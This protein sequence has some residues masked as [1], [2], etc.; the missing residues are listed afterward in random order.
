MSLYSSMVL[1]PSSLVIVL[2][3]AALLVLTT[4]TPCWYVMVT[5]LE[6][7]VILNSETVLS[8]FQ[9]E[10][11]HSATL[12]HPINSSSTKVA[13]FLSSTLKAANISFSD[14]VTKVAPLLFQAF[15]TVPHLAQISY[16]GMEG[17]FFSYYTDNDKVLAMYS[18]S[19][20]PSTSPW[21][22][23]KAKVY[24]IQPVNRDTG[25]LYGEA[26]VSEPSINSSLFAQVVINSSNGHASLGTKWNHAHDLLFISSAR[27]TG[28][29]GVSLGFPATTIANFLSH[30]GYQGASL[31]L[32][33]KDGKVLVEGIQ[34]TSMVIYNDTVSFQSVN[35]NGDHT[36][37]YDGTVSCKGG[38]GDVTS[39]L[40]I[41]DTEYLIH[42]SPIDIMGIESVY[43]LA[44]P[45]NGLVRYV[46]E[47]KKKGLTLMTVMM[48]MA[49]VA[50][51]SFLFT[52]VRLLKREM[53]LCAS[54]IKQMEAT[55][56]AERKSM[57]KSHAFASATHDVRASLAGLT[58]LIEMCYHE[59]VPDSELETNLKQMDSCTKDLLGLLNSI[60]DTSK[61]EAGK[62][63]LEEEEFDIFQLL[64]D[65]VDLYHPVGMKK[66]VEIVMDPCDGSLLRYSRTKGDRGKLKQVLCNLLSNAVKF[67]SEGHIA[68]RAW[69]RKPSLK[70]SLNA[71]NRYRLKR[72]L[73]CVFYR[74]KE[75]LD[76]IE[77]I[78][79]DPNCMDFTF[80]VD[81]TGIG[82]PKEKY[83]SVFENYVQV[84][85][86]AL[87]HEGTGL[88]L[89]IVR[90][91]VRL[92]HGDIGIMDKDIG[93]KGTCFRFNVL[94][95]V[96][97]TQTNGETI[98][99]WF[100]SRGNQAQGL[101]IRTTSPASSMGS[102][103]PRLPIISPSPRPEASQVVLLIQNE[104]RLRTN[105]RFM[106][107]LGIKVKVVKE[108][109][110]LSYTLRKIKQ[111]GLHSTSPRSPWSSSDSPSTSF[112][113]ARGVR[114]SAMD[115][116]DYMNS[117]FKK[118]DIEATMSF[119]LIVIDANAGPFSELCMVISDFKRGLNN[120][121]RV[122][123]LEKPLMPGVD[124]KFL[125]EDASHS[126]DIV[127][128]KPF[129]GSRLFKVIRI[130]PEYGGVWQC[131]SSIVNKERYQ[132]S[133]SAP[134]GASQSVEG[135]KYDRFK[136]GKFPIHQGEIQE[137]GGSSNGK[138]LRG[139]KFLVVEDH[140]LLRRITKANLER[141]DAS[142]EE[143]ENGE[144]AVGL[145]EE[146]L[147]RNSSNP[148]YDYILMD[149]QMPVMGGY[150]ATR[151]IREIEKPYGVRI[152]I[153]ALTA[154]TG[155]EAKWSIEAGMDDHLVKPINQV[156][157]L[158][159]VRNIHNKQ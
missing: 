8:Q 25:E 130:L 93:E 55:Q 147:T 28:V 94:L 38:D 136:A 91:L 26:I 100:G 103:N 156:A 44:V 90:S 2:A 102:M 104:E 14:I 63:Q 9:S 107:N 10:I 105:Q 17:L 82:I 19:S 13:K 133:S 153:F 126:N 101:T 121:T 35:V 11:E 20:F 79:Y 60:L 148:P 84:K 67:T 27:I 112:G 149:C 125:E 158:E 85:E 33:T 49:L 118:T 98:E 124:F 50:M 4:L 113:R 123:W 16:M 70:S 71:T 66:G 134:E 48:V 57:N 47:I 127:L 138:S 1:R 32:A 89:G 75:A 41:Q 36:S 131:N 7:R 52:N 151:R 59:V 146:G 24:H 45:N 88:G 116:S 43:V 92:M 53:H 106:K 77:A 129:H 152:P 65:V 137:C 96:H 37:Y 141:L 51:L 69:A 68:V 3:Y 132:A 114:L 12:I 99:C 31:Y 58:G 46:H 97:E 40:N 29:G 108:W 73:S 150:E 39:I 21:S 87:G 22:A 135:R 155:E 154:N 6:Q 140:V 139:M 72:L 86:T 64:E 81:D 157:L 74:K 5:Q 117:I 76:D 142:I 34:N 83:K 145:V 61:I 143:C 42:C 159:A 18:N 120:P 95:T 62:M 78:Q 115:G 54:L 15:E 30:V 144:E 109:R 23:S 110:D 128:C 119:I 111:K 122:V 56:Q 80:E